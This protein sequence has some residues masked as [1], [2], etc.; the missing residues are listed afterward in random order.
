[1]RNCPIFLVWNKL[2]FSIIGFIIG[3]YHFLLLLVKID[4]LSLASS[5]PVRMRSSNAPG[6]STQLLRGVSNDGWIGSNVSMPPAANYETNSQ[7]SVR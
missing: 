7:S 6:A 4:E 2:A 5:V 3:S 1:M